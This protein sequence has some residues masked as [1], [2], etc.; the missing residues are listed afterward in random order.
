MLGSVYSGNDI[1]AKGVGIGYSA[2]FQ[3]S[4]KTQ[5][6][7]IVL[8]IMALQP[9]FERVSGFTFRLLRI[10]SPLLAY[11]KKEH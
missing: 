4:K 2:T 9:A 6:L 11:L 8:H 1:V 3:R 5:Q 10:S 7:K